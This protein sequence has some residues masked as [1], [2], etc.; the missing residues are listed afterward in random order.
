MNIKEARV[1]VESRE[2][3]DPDY[4]EAVKMCIEDD[5]AKAV[6]KSPSEVKSE[7]KPEVKSGEKKLG[8]DYV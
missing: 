6:Q 5:E 1:L 3:L 8:V 2:K 4:A 7:V